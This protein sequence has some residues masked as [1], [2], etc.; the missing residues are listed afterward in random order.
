MAKIQSI[1]KPAANKPKQQT[2]EPGDA[3]RFAVDSIGVCLAACERIRDCS[4]SLND[5]LE[6]FMAS[7]DEGL[8]KAA[9]I[10]EPAVG[11]LSDEITSEFPDLDGIRREL[12]RRGYADKIKGGPGFTEN[13]IA[14]IMKSRGGAE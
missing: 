5:T 10:V 7:K 4:R 9:S 8:L 3:F 11:R 2:P 13:E 12:I 14:E 1:K 6:L